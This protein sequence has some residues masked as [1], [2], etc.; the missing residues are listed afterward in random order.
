MNEFCEFEKKY[1]PALLYIAY[2][3]LILHA[4]YVFFNE[5][6]TY[7]A[8][9]FSIAALVVILYTI[10]I[11]FFPDWCWQKVGTQV[12]G[13]APYDKSAVPDN[14]FPGPHPGVWLQSPPPPT[15]V[16]PGQSAQPAPPDAYHAPTYS[17]PTAAPAYPPQHGDP[18]AFYG[19]LGNAGGKRVVPFTSNRGYGH[20]VSQPL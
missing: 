10:R 19:E 9:P 18:R 7:D 3:P 12:R 4:L 5:P 2:V 8:S 11:A 17:A 13:G 20:Y 14:D 6:L 16:P 1:G 15:H